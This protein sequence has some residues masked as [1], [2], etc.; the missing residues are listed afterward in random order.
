QGAP[1]FPRSDRMRIAAVGSALP[2]HYYAQETLTAWLQQLWRE[3]PVASSRLPQLHE[4]ARV[5][6]RHLA[7]PLERYAAL[8]DF[9]ACNAVWL[10]C[11]LEL[12]ERAAATALQRAGLRPQEVDAIFFSTVTGLASPSLDALLVNRMGLRPDVRRLPLFGLGCVAGA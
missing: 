3:H 12:G 7:L 6:G 9:G 2:A 8:G 11:A 10:R 4:H 5:R 1:P